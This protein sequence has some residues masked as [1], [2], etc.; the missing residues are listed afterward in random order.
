[1]IFLLLVA[2][3]TRQIH[4][5]IKHEAEKGCGEDCGVE[6]C[7]RWSHFLAYGPSP[8]T[9]LFKKNGVCQICYH[10]VRVL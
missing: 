7:L 8:H 9:S 1:M 3:A 6:A 2:I 5:M 4:E 10:L